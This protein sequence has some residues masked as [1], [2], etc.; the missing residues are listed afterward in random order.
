MSKTNYV[1]KDEFIRTMASIHGTTLKDARSA[2][3]AVLDTLLSLLANGDNVQF[4]GDLTFQIKET[5]PRTY[6]LNGQEY[7]KPAKR[8][9]VVKAGACF[10]SAVNE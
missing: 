2:T 6:S 4:V 5:A 8:K 7:S 9:V 10:N 3:N 1:N